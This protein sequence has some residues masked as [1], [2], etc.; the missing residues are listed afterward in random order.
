[1]SHAVCLVFMLCRAR[2]AEIPLLY[3]GIAPPERTLGGGCIAPNLLC[4]DTQNLPWAICRNVLE[5]F[6]CINFGGFSRG[7]SWRIFLGIFSHKNEEKKSGEKIREKIFFA[8]NASRAMCHNSVPVSCRQSA[9]TRANAL[10]SIFIRM[11][12]SL[13]LASSR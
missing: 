6:C 11:F 4:G 5:E 8:T 7:F 12:A 9:Y 13:R 3:G 2:I 10:K 1:M